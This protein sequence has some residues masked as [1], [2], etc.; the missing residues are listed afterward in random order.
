MN[1]RILSFN[2][3]DETIDYIKAKSKEAK[4]SQSK[5][6]S[7]ILNHEMM[8]DRKSFLSQH[9]TNE[10]IEE[11][12]NELKDYI[13]ETNT[14]QTKILVQFIKNVLIEMANAQ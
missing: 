11:T 3:N 7:I 13:K 1:R 9:G 6:V 5:F 10:N 8:N 14:E 12:I 4:I 2:L